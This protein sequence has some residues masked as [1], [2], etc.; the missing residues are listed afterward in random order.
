MS[1]VEALAGKT[2]YYFGSDCKINETKIIG[3]VSHSKLR[4]VV[5]SKEMAEAFLAMMQLVTI[6]DS[7]NEIDGFTPQWSK[8]K[9]NWTINNEANSIIVAFWY[10]VSHPLVFSCREKAEQFLKTFPE[11]LEKAKRL[12]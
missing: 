5:A 11:L 8:G 4:D 1:N 9:S 12:L 7:W 10:S 2:G 6:C 3:E